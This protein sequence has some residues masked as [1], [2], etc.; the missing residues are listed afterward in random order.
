LGESRRA[1]NTQQTLNGMLELL[2]ALDAPGGAPRPFECAETGSTG[3]SLPSRHVIVAESEALDPA[4][5]KRLKPGHFLVTEDE[6]GLAPAL[7]GAL[8]SRGCSVTVVPRAALADEERLALWTAAE[9]AN[10]STVAGIVHAAPVA[11]GWLPI[12]TAL[13]AWRVQLLIQEK[14]LFLLLRGFADRLAPD[15]QL[16]AVSALGGSF[17]RLPGPARGVA[18]VANESDRRRSQPRRR[19]HR[20]R[21]PGRAR[22][23]RRPAGD[24][25]PR[26]RAHGVPHPSGR[27]GNR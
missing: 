4:A 22:D 23:E 8:A 15:A 5:S 6:V 16:L 21:P 1:L 14:S 7:V 11:A 19:C 12:D 3:Q 13:D 20:R 9:R 17:G 25:V 26:R 27:D 2:S 10:L 24:R 18:E